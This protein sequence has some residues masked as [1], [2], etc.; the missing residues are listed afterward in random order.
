MISRPVSMGVSAVMWLEGRLGRPWREQYCSRDQGDGEAGVSEARQARGQ[1]R[2]S[3]RR[4]DDERE[5]QAVDEPIGGQPE[6]ADSRGHEGVE[7]DHR[8]HRGREGLKPANGSVARASRRD[9]GRDLSEGENPDEWTAHLPDNAEERAVAPGEGEGHAKMREQGEKPERAETESERGHDRCLLHA[10]P[11][12]PVADPPA[13]AEQSQRGRSVRGVDED[14]GGKERHGEK[15]SAARVFNPIH[16]REGHEGDKTP[17]EPG[18]DQ[19]PSQAFFDPAPRAGRQGQGNE[20]SG[21]GQPA[22]AEHALEQRESGDTREHPRDP[23]HGF[24]GPRDAESAQRRGVNDGAEPCCAR[25]IVLE[26]SV[27]GPPAGIQTPGRP[28][29]LDDLM[30]AVELAGMIVEGGK[31]VAEGGQAEDHGVDQ[32]QGGGHESSAHA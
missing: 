25:R 3:K 28:A 22:V 14:D 27:A 16:E 19:S 6:R 12:L 29:E 9:P 15:R 8:G 4:P 30:E 1:T 11:S 5:E 7:G 32:E 31:T 13:R 23:D 26:L 20:G 2:D 18:R 17:S 21:Q 10:L 24:V